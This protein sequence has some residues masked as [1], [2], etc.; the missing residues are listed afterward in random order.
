MLVIIPTCVSFLLLLPGIQTRV[1]K[2]IT[3]RLSNDFKTEISIKRVRLSPFLKISL[4]GVLIRDQQ[5]DTL[6]FAEKVQTDIESLSFKQKDLSFGKIRVESPFVNIYEYNKKMN[7]SFFLDSLASSSSTDSVKWSYS[8]KGVSVKSGRIAFDHSILKN[9]GSIKEKLNFYDLDFDLIRSVNEQE[10]LA[11]RV[12]NFSI[13]EDIGLFIK[14]LSAQFR[15]N[16]ERIAVNNLAFRT[17]NSYF[18]FGLLEMPLGNEE[19]LDKESQFR[20]EILDVALSSKDVRKLFAGFPNFEY[21]LRLSGLVYGSLD[22]LKGRKVTCLFGEQSRLVTSFD[23]SGLSNFNE[24][25]VFLDV[26]DLQTNIADIEEV[27]IANGN[28]KSQKLPLSLHELGTISYKGNFTGFTNDLVAYGT[29]R[30]N[31]GT[32]NTDLGIKILPGHN[33]IY[34]GL[35]STSGFDIGR[36]LNMDPVM[37]E[38]TLDVEVSGNRKS[39][40]DYFVF[41]DGNI[42]SIEYNDYLYR[43]IELQGLLTHQ[44][45]DGSVRIDDP[46]G[47]LDFNGKVDMSGEIPHF[48]F[49]ALLAN[50]QFDRLKLLPDFKDGVLSLNIETN[51]E[52]DNLDDLV[53]DI[54]LSNGLLFTPKASIVIDSLTV[55]AVKEGN[56]KHLVLKSDFVDGELKGHYY[57]GKFKKT[58]S[59]YIAHFIPSFSNE[60]QKQ[61]ALEQNNFEFE[62][63]LK[64]MKNVASVFFPDVSLSD[65]G[66]LKGSFNSKQAKLDIEG[67]LDY[68]SVDNIGAEKPVF[69]LAS[70]NGDQVILTLRSSQVTYGNS[71][72]LPDFS[73]YQKAGRDTLQTNIFWNNWGDVV[74]SGALYSTTNFKSA[75]DGTLETTVN[76]HPS[77]LIISDLEWKLSEANF[78]FFADGLSVNGF[79]IEHQDQFVKLDGLMHRKDEDGLF[80]TFNKLDL[81]RFI[82]IDSDNLSFSGTVNGTLSLKEFFRVPLLSSNL[83]IDEFVF[84]GAR[85]GTFG[86]NSV[87]NKDIEALNVTTFLTDNQKEHLHGEGLFYPKDKQLDF[88]FDIDSLNVAFLTPFL[89]NIVQNLKGSA[90][91]K[92]FLKGPLSNPFLTGKV[93]LNDGLFSVG[94]LQTSYSLTDSVAF[95][96]NEMRFKEM[97]LTDQYGHKGRFSGSIYHEAFSSMIYNLRVDINNMLVLNTK[98][99]DN[100]YYYGTVFANGNMKLTGNGSNVNIEINGKTRPNTQFYIPLQ[101]NEEASENNFIRFTSNDNS[102]KAEIAKDYSVDLSGV[103]MDMDIEVTPDAKIQIVF[104]ERLGDILQSTGGGNIQIRMDRQGNLR[105]YG[106]YTI[107]EGEYLFSLQNLINKRFV[108]NQGGTVK[109][110]GDPYNAIIDITAVYKLRASAAD[111]LDAISASSSESSD[112]QR[113]IPVNCNLMLTDM[114]QQPVIKFGIETPT[115]DESRESLLLEYISS[116]DELNRQV[117]S[118]LLLNK[119]YVPEYLKTTDDATSRNDNAALVTTTE[120]LSNQISRW[121]STISSDV[122]VGVAYRPGDNLTSEE[123]ELALSTQVFNNRVTINGNVG[124]GKYQTNTSKMVGDFDMDVK[125]NRSGTLRARAYTRSNDDIIYETSPT[126]QGVGLSFKEEFNSFKELL[127]KY[128]DILLG[129]KDKEKVE[130]EDK[131]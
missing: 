85:L 92:M 31:L 10:S 95:Y 47:R 106:D 60:I 5:S 66:F 128:R 33:L 44:K 64:E 37:G 78:N 118:L 42:A 112:L 52:G 71:I 28:G 102:R 29:F 108:I 53:G 83:E 93:K 82:N 20:A 8:I 27:V 121:F 103:N 74:Y 130:E 3:T 45:F 67:E 51:F 99:K 107:D 129:K 30:T 59:N 77:S 55:K 35:L 32:L 98:L 48:N 119:F 122:D 4:E 94:L 2:N 58:L 18:N 1:V 21:P 22:N 100:P 14:D 63:Q 125:I 9:P 34:A 76:L 96:P 80:M 111:L 116:E 89:D 101:D 7:Y 84:N 86:I 65:K 110:Q 19:G 39:D 127:H 88:K 6:F 54:R 36:L 38:L 40:S 16:N 131:D 68:C 81:T 49:S 70:D 69:R 104:D 41:L 109:W 43:N 15:F 26:E 50:V 115:L 113:R 75:P 114:L 126:T 23:I 72:K 61:S 12:Y 11:F 24:T 56:S 91:G 17:N 97:T 25:F 57:F 87:W 105:F 62:L 123:F 90:S 120:M 73:I 13:K 79:K 46:N 124:Y 117:L